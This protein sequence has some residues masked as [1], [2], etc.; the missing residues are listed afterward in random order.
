MKDKTLQRQLYNFLHNFM[1]K[2]E[3]QKISGL[4][5]VDRSTTDTDQQKRGSSLL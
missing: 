2:G 5:K 1:F 4:T 3:V